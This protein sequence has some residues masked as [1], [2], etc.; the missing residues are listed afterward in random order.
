VR[1]KTVPLIECQCGEILAEDVINDVGIP[2]V[3]CNTVINRYIKERLISL[4][5][6]SIKVYSPGLQFDDRNDKFLDSFIEVYQKSVLQIK[7][8]VNELS[9][10]KKLNYLKVSSVCSQVLSYIKEINIVI[11]YLAKIKKYDD[12]TYYHSIN[13]AFYSLLLANWLKLTGDELNKVVLAGLLHDIGKTKVPLDVLNK[14][15]KLLPEEFEEIKRHSMQ[16]YLI[17]KESANIPEVVSAAVL[18]HHEREDGSGYPNGL[19]GHEISQYA[20]IIAIA[21]VFDAMTS[22][23]VYHR[24]AS[25]F[26]VFREFQSFGPKMFDINMLMTFVRN[27]SP[28]YLGSK[29]LLNNGAIGEVVYIPPFDVANPVINLEGQ[30]IDMSRTSEYTIQSLV[31]I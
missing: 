21:D 28:C 2:I 25:P 3:V 4:G 14:P 1:K 26:D 7:E 23:R 11:K 10:G 29:V 31:D 16:G 8:V 13:V 15:G 5:I 18:M 17:L 27:L 6:K 20:K 9:M 12:Y 19:R 30:L 24:A 22:S